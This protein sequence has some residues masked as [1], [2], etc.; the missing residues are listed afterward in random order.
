HGSA[1]T[2]PVEPKDPAGAEARN[3]RHQLEAYHGHKGA[4]A[5]DF[6]WKYLGDKDRFLRYAARLAIESQPVEQ[7]KDRALKESN[8]TAALQSLLALARLGGNESQSALLIALQK[9][10]LKSLSEEEKLDKIRVVEVSV[11]RDGLPEHADALISEFDAAY[12]SASIPLN[13]ELC[14]TLITFNAPDAVAKSIKL[15]KAAPTQEEQITYI[16]YL[17]NA[18]TGWTMDLRKTYF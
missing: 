13:R 11:A 8:S 15:L 2:A 7:W 17:R 10:P 16:H 18:K 3:T 5:V 12:P 9:F 14:E 1:S 6:A 4:K